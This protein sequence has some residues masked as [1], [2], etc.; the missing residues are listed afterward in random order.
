ML[1]SR[2]IPTCQHW[3]I[4]ERSGPTWNCHIS[5]SVPQ[6]GRSGIMC[7]TIL[8]P[9][10]FD[11]WND[12]DTAR[13]V[14]PRLVSLATSYVCEL[15]RSHKNVAQSAHL[16]DTLYTNLE[17]CASV[18]EHLTTQSALLHQGLKSSPQVR[19]QAVIRP[20]LDCD[21]YTSR[22]AQFGEPDDQLQ[23]NKSDTVS[24]LDGLVDIFARVPT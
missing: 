24:L 16:I 10:S 15:R 3:E 12:S 18:S 19:F 7:A 13:T 11:M 4:G 5:R 8:Y 22:L 6:L 2:R 23:P 21:S 17:T 9:A 1:G 20:S 14:C